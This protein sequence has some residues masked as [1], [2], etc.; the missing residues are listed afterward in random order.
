MKQSPPVYDNNTMLQSIFPFTTE[1]LDQ[2]ASETKTVS[3]RRSQVKNACVN[4]QKA[5][6]KCD[7]G[8][9]CQRCIKLG[10]T[11]TCFD[12]PRKERK[13]GFK[14]GPYRKKSTSTQPSS[15]KNDVPENISSSS[16]S[17]P[18]F[19]TTTTTTA[20][21]SKVVVKK[22]KIEPEPIKI[23]KIVSPSDII[24]QQ[25]ENTIQFDFPTSNE[26]N[27][28]ETQFMQN[29]MTTTPTTT[30]TPNYYTTLPSN[31]H[32]TDFYS[33][34]PS[35]YYYDN[36]TT[37]SSSPQEGS[38]TSRSGTLPT[39][40][41]SSSFTIENELY[42]HTQNTSSFV[43]KLGD[44]GLTL[45][46]QHYDSTNTNLFYDPQWLTNVA[47]EFQYYPSNVMY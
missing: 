39:N 27:F 20:K 2:V 12:S 21:T 40:W 35:Y 43:P 22:E 41:S 8:R 45:D 46:K 17:S 19:I 14:R 6:K 28:D 9:P 16:T 30:T 36:N 7:E 33:T 24:Y 47:S 3:K 29:T 18:L 31:N 32:T 5:C 44:N 11:D 25:V 10:I 42:H 23:E 15:P 1:S 13:K 37:T 4:C 34:H 38:F 26:Y